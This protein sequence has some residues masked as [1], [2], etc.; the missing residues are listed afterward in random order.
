METKQHSQK[1]LQHRRLLTVLPLLVFPFLS[2]A[3]WA[4]GG[5]SKNQT[6]AKTDTGLNLQLPDA[7]LKNESALDKLS[8]Y[9]AAD[10]DS[11]R[12]VEDLRNDPYYKDNLER[13]LPVYGKTGLNLSAGMDANEQ[14]IYSKVAELQK[15]VD[16]SASTQIQTN[17]NASDA[18]L[19]KEVD[20]LQNMMQ[21]IGK[22]ENDPEMDALNGTLEK[23]LD[24]QH[25]SRVK[26]K[27][28]QKK[29]AMF[30]VTYEPPAG[31]PTFFGK[32][33]DTATNKNVF[34]EDNPKPMQTKEANAVAAVVQ[35]TQLLTTGSVIKLRLLT[36]IYVNGIRIGCGSFVYGNT[37]IDNERL[38]ITVPSIRY[39]NS[40]LPV[41]LSVYDMD[42]LA[43]IYIPGSIKDEV[44]RQS[45]DQNLQS[46][47]LM[48]MDPSLKAQATA[49]GIGAVKSF[50]SKKVRQVKVTV[51]AG[52]K[53]L[54]RD[55]NQQNY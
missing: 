41:A 43:G 36:D 3:F 44:V 6:V 17:D 13:A 5:G 46:L 4:L 34:Y 15:Q 22:N 26:E 18:Q 19:S 53:V 45:V 1:F 37:Y 48:S 54:L 10:A 27:S 33:K 32:R 2:M 16:Q 31:I 12:R 11:A 20:R 49:A 8:F 51:K 7:Q 35:E 40:V 42:G 21:T 14:R 30:P 39:E 47:E 25:P 38:I 50:L 24:I 28:L 29:T 55:N 23:I 9:K 52:Y